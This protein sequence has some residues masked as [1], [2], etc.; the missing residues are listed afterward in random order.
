MREADDHLHVPNAME[1]WEPNSLGS[2]WAT[3]GLLRDSFTLFYIR[4]YLCFVFLLLCVYL[5]FCTYLYVYVRECECI[6]VCVCFMCQY[7]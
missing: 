2:L 7:I 1:I 5:C 6:C 4:V 3:P